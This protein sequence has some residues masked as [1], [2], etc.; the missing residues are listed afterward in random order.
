MT[1]VLVTPAYLPTQ[2]DSGDTT[3]FGPTAWKAPRLFGGGAAGDAI[4]RDAAS[5]TGASWRNAGWIDVRAYG[6]KGD[7]VTDDAPAIQAAINALPA[8][9]GGTIYFPHPPS[10]YKVGSTLTIGKGVRLIGSGKHDSVIA[11][12]AGG[13]NVV[14][15]TVSGGGGGIEIAHLQIQCTNA[16]DIALQLKGVDRCHV[17]DCYLYATV[18]NATLLQIDRNGVAGAYTHRIVN[19]ILQFPSG[20]VSQ[21]G[22]ALVGGV[23]STVIFANHLLADHAIVEVAGAFAHG[24]NMILANLF[25]SVTA[26]PTGVGLACAGGAAPSSD[27]AIA[28]NYFDNY[29]TGISL[30]VGTTLMM[31]GAN[32]WDNV[33]TKISDANAG[34]TGGSLIDLFTKQISLGSTAGQGAGAY[35]AQ[36]DSATDAIGYRTNNVHAGGRGWSWLNGV[37]AAGEFGLRDDTAGVFPTTWDVN[38]ITHA[39][40]SR[41]A[42][43]ANLAAAG[44]L[45]LGADG[46]AFAITGNTTINAV[47]VANWTAGSIVTLVFTGTPTVKHN[48][49]GGAGTARIFL[50][51]SVDFVAAAN[52]LLALLYDGTQW[53]ETARK[54][55]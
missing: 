17:H 18:A 51:G 40:R 25:S 28:W 43:G 47:I 46:N 36:G 54:V 6:A 1:D 5:A 20:H 19:N 13:P 53:Q 8:N 37:S 4:V 52:S 23:T 12:V 10:F 22:I 32:V 34:Q 21:V 16:G 26:G 30:A 2:P 3:R 45:T 49:G 35:F 44:D 50:A 41:Q 9:Q 33:T 31:I 14:I 55:A 38:G 27:H 42:K 48:T 24:G 11:N 7:G 15:S 29:V 39:K